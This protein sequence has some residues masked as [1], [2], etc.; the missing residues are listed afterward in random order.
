MKAKELIVP[1]LS[2]LA[3]GTCAALLI[4]KTVLFEEHRLNGYQ[5]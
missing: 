5:S 1:I 4:R 3:I 2:I